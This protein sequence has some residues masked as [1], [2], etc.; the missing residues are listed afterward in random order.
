MQFHSNQIIGILWK[1]SVYHTIGHFL[2][3][4][5]N[6]LDLINSILLEQEDLLSLSQKFSLGMEWSFADSINCI[7][8]LNIHLSDS[9]FQFAAFKIF[10]YENSVCFSV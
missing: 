3:P 5:E 1:Y 7:P 8:F 2:F 10:T 4:F 9:I 6:K